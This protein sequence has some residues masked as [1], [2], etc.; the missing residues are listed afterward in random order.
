ML[1]SEGE[2]ASFMQCCRNPQEDYCQCLGSACMAWRFWD[3][4]LDTPGDQGYCGLAGRPVFPTGKN[5]RERGGDAT[6]E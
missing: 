4:H 1:V 3:S 5:A 6:M 2:Y